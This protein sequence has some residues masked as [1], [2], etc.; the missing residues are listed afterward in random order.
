MMS[1]AEWCLLSAIMVILLFVGIPAFKSK[2]VKHEETRSFI[3]WNQDGS[4]LVEAEGVPWDDIYV[5]HRDA[6]I[7]YGDE[8]FLSVP[9]RVTIDHIEID[10]SLQGSQNE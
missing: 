3:C 9:C 8:Y 2:S 1:R 7:R 10:T 5:D 4:V 6:S